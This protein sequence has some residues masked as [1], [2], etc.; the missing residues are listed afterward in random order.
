MDVDL[1][2]DSFLACDAFEQ[3]SKAWTLAFAQ[4]VG[5]FGEVGPRNESVGMFA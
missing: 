3:F 5:R 1:L 2:G 4:A